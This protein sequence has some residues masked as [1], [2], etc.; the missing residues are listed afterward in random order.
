M[1]EY[2]QGNI[3]ELRADHVVID[4]N[5]IAYM[6]LISFQSYEKIGE[7]KQIRIFTHLQVK[8]DS[9]T[10]YGFMEKDERVMFRQ[11]ISIS[12]VGPATAR[13][14]L[15]SIP[16]SDLAEAI[17]NA[18]EAT[19]KRIKGIGPKTAK[20]IILDLRDKIDPAIAQ[21]SSAT[22][23]SADQKTEALSALASLGFSRGEAT[24][25]I[26]QLIKSAA[27]PPTTEELIRTALQVLSGQKN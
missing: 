25:T 6:V 26:N 12:G 15:S 8:E 7:T 18:D 10:L 4:V 19:F 24:K 13:V 5:G 1:I 27:S 22:G 17:I 9:H 2:L 14:A 16:A 20:R 11:L 21:N 23:P 3:A